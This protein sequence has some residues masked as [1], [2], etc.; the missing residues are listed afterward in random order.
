MKQE[1]CTLQSSALFNVRR[2]IEIFSPTQHR[3][4]RVPWKQL[5][6]LTIFIQSVAAALFSVIEV[7]FAV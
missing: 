2:V 6:S 4:S 7:R 3:L 1:C 5:H